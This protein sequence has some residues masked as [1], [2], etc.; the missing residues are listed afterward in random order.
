MSKQLEITLTV[1]TVDNDIL[2][3][4]NERGHRRL[5]RFLLKII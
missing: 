2:Q 1:A 3:S 4:E 5:E